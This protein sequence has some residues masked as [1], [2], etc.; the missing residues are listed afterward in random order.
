METEFH[1]RDDG[2]YLEMVVVITAEK[3]ECAS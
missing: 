3:C 1:F 2:K